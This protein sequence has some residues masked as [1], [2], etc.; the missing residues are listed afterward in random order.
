VLGVACCWKSGESTEHG[1]YLRLVSRCKLDY[2]IVVIEGVSIL[3]DREEEKVESMLWYFSTRSKQKTNRANCPDEE[4][5]ASYVGRLLENNEATQLESHFAECTLCAEDVVAVRKAAQDRGERA[6]PQ[7]VVNR[8]MSLV[9][10]TRPQIL[11]LEIRLTKDSM[12][13]IR[14]SGK[15]VLSSPLHSVRAAPKTEQ[16]AILQIEEEIAKFKVMVQVQQLEPW[17]CQVVVRI[18]EIN[19]PADGIRVSLFSA[20][21]ER[22]SYLTRQGQAVFDRLPVGAYSLDLSDAGAPLGTIRLTLME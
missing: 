5:L 16:T 15:L 9:P 2:K 22:A 17:R 6:V 14:A 4:T 10:D 13:L 12:E 8:A 19:R 3:S 1:V 20:D 7:H 11:H 21:R 18:A